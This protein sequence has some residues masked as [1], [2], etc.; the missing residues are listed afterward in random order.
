M[1]GP[2]TVRSITS[3]KEFEACAQDWDSA[4]A[5]TPYASI[6]ARHFWLKH[7]LKTVG[8]DREMAFRL[9]Y[10]SDGVLGCAA[11]IRERRSFQLF[12]AP[13]LSLAGN[14][15]SKRTQVILARRQDEAAVA[16][17]KDLNRLRWW[18]LDPER[19][20]DNDPLLRSIKSSS[21][22]MDAAE[23]VSYTLPRVATTMRWDDYL[24]ERSRK[25]RKQRKRGHQDQLLSI[26][27]Y[28]QDFASAGDFVAAIAAVAHNSW[29]FR[30]G[31]SIISIEP[32]WKFWQGVLHEAAAQ[33]TLHASCAFDGEMPVA[34]IFGIIEHGVLYA[35]KTAFAEA[36][37][38]AGA[39]RFAFSAIIQNAME[40][41]AVHTVD[42][43]FITSHGDYKT[44]WATQLETVRSY[45]AFRQAVGPRMLA[46]AYEFKK[47]LDRKPEENMPQ[48]SEATT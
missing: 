7:W 24:K 2:I 40:N 45:Y 3:L 37:A 4:V 30:E 19:V 31:T 44:G 1:S 10:D 18:W 5:Q 6:H 33:G 35:L 42:L 41:P 38:Q 21:I 22:V 39:G 17:L 32:E 11:W 29:A 16:M 34:F 23:R 14:P 9:M 43:D 12:S 27:N 48:L 28:P 36:G 25:F 26:R 46:R 15:M 47:R 20:H 8:Q 13:Y